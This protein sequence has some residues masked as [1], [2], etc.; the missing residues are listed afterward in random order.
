MSERI[1]P[2]FQDFLTAGN[3]VP[4]KY[5]TYYAYWVSRFLAFV[6]KN[7]DMKLRDRVHSFLEELRGNGKKADWQVQQA[8]TAINVYL[9]N[10]LDG[11][12]SQFYPERTKQNDNLKMRHE[13]KDMVCRMRDV[14]RV[15]HYAYRTEKSYLDWVN[16]FY[17]YL[18]K[19][20]GTIDSKGVKDFLTY[21]ALNRNVAASTQN[22][23]F[24]ALLFLFRNVL[25]KDLGGTLVKR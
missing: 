17:Q 13:C 4:D 24:N 10:F 11:D 25:D 5:I 19:T 8:E 14:L 3:I 2:E 22:Q 20:N 21:L 18:E 16:R 7:Q 1:L 12:V 9:N 23:A 6:N 15:R